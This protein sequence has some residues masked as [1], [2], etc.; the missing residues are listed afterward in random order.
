MIKK[1]LI[2]GPG[3]VGDMVMAQTL[4]KI[5]KQQNP[6]ILIDVLAPAWAE[7]LLQRMP[8]VNQ[9]QLSPFQHG[10]LKLKERY[11]LAKKLRDECYEQV[12]LTPN[13]IK[14]TLIPFLA[15]IPIR[16][17]WRGEWPRHW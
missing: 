9:F 4:F 11:K 10:E 14:S 15:K 6:E 1:L 8:E 2:V 3:W 12:I 13:S 17:G 7:S 16:T 5:L